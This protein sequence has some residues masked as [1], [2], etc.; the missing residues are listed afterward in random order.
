M[1][2]KGIFVEDLDAVAE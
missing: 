1:L 2:G